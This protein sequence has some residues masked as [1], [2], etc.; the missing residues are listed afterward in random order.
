MLSYEEEG[1]K[2]TGDPQNILKSTDLLA[3]N[4]ETFLILLL[5]KVF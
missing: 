1:H 3:K 2:K 5:E 4:Y